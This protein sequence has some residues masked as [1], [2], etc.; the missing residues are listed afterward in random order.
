[1]SGESL[2]D[3][4]KANN[5]TT[6]SVNLS[7]NKVSL[8]NG[9]LDILK[10]ASHSSVVSLSMDKPRKADKSSVNE[11]RY[12]C[13][14]KFPFMK[15]AAS[16]VLGT[17][18]IIF[19][20]LGQEGLDRMAKKLHAHQKEMDKFEKTKSSAKGT[21][22]QPGKSNKTLRVSKDGGAHVVTN[23]VK[24]SSKS[25]VIKKNKADKKVDKAQTREALAA[26]KSRKIAKS[27]K[28]VKSA[29]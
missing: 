23:I 7:R 8:K 2:E 24:T 27:K 9:S 14:E 5:A 12:P 29:S 10:G 16:E 6:G 25:H 19:Q 18:D 28:V 26:L 1:M 20:E 15:R 13:I 22:V 4:D 3:K 21:P 11:I 17:D